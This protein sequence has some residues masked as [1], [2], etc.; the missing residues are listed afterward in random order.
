MLML[1]LIQSLPDKDL[2]GIL[3]IILGI[4]LLSI[5]VGAIVSHDRES[6]GSPSNG[7]SNQ[8]VGKS[9]LSSIGKINK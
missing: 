2:S 3:Y 6:S 8:P 9:G 5:F 4:L 7:E 1:G